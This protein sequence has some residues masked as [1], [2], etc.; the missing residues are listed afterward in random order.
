[1]MAG[2]NRDRNAFFDMTQ[3]ERMLSNL[4]TFAKVIA[5]DESKGKLKAQAGEIT[6]A[7]LGIA[8]MR[9]GEDRH[10][11]LPEVGEQVVIV[12]PSGDLNQG[13]VVGSLYCDAYPAPS[14]HQSRHCIRYKNGT[15]IEYDRET[16]TLT[17]HCVGHIVT[18]AKTITIQA[19]THH[20][21]DISIDGNVTIN[22][23]LSTSGNASVAGQLSASGG[24]LG[25][26]GL[27]FEQHTHTDSRGGSTSTPH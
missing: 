18:N 22:G 9:A 7:W 6:S 8:T 2:I 12:A 15:T 14:N 25:V 4:I 16:D 1:M 27:S 19:T 20:Q 11:W 21:G 10:W 23:N 5:V 3:I 17:T 26:G 24:L 13:V